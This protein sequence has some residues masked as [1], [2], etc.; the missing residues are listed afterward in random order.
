MNFVSLY[1][2]YSLLLLV[3]VVVSI[4]SPWYQTVIQKSLLVQLVKYL[5][6]SR[7][8]PGFES[9]TESSFFSLFVCSLRFLFKSITWL[10]QMLKYLRFHFFFVS[11]IYYCTNSSS[12]SSS[13]Y[14]SSFSSYSYPRFHLFIFSFQIFFILLL[15]FFVIIIIITLHCI[16]LFVH[17]L[18]YGGVA[19]M[20]E[21]SLCMRG[22]A[23]SMPA[24][25]TF[26]LDLRLFRGDCCFF[27]GQD[28]YVR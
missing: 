8:R 28:I 17:H 9:P 11:C 21:H 20:V 6:L 16:F 1:I 15:F 23:G 5:R 24:T 25:S 3:V 14:S 13:S 7:E 27:L 18:V 26:L 10:Y 2:L 4:L 22:A 19:Q 12:S